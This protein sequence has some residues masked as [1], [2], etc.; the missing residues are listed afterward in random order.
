MVGYDVFL[1]FKHSDFNGNV[2]PDT[3]IAKKLY[4]MF[5]E[6]KKSVF[7]SDVTLPQ[8]GESE[9]KKAIDEA[10]EA[11][12]VLVVICTN[13][14]YVKT[15]WVEY[16]WD[17]FSNDI[18]SNYKP[19][20]KIYSFIDDV[21]PADLPLTLRSRQLFFLKTDG[22]KKAVDYICNYLEGTVIPEKR[23]KIPLNLT[24]KG[25]FLLNYMDN[26][27]Q[28]KKIY[29]IKSDFD[30]NLHSRKQCVEE[31]KARPLSLLIQKLKNRENDVSKLFEDYCGIPEGSGSSNEGFVDP[32]DLNKWLNGCA[33]IIDKTINC[34]N[35]TDG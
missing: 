1:S 7:F 33:K 10:L 23:E 25:E 4:D 35:K 13:P 15:R 17:T 8:M 5:T 34:M 31:R 32:M 29:E 27:K 18:L 16:E 20:G 28:L 11:S 6:R 26:K 30:L 9:F 22:F 14:K 24:D 3:A 2:T 12:T 21:N 19:K